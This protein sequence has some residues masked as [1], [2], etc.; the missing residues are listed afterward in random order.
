ME[1]V[2]RESDKHKKAENTLGYFRL[3]ENSL[4]R[5][6]LFCFFRQVYNVNNVGVVKECFREFLHLIGGQII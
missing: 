3:K 5:T 6:N 1:I 4:V 2:E